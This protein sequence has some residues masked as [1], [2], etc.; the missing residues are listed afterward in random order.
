MPNRFEPKQLREAAE[1][2]TYHDAGTHG[3][4][5]RLVWERRNES[6][7]ARL[8][9]GVEFLGKWRALRF[10]GG[11]TAFRRIC[12]T[13]LRKNL[14]DLQH[15]QGRDLYSLAPEDFQ[16]VLKD[17]FELP[18]LRSPSNH[19]WQSTPFLPPRNCHGL[20]PSNSQ[21][22]IQTTLGPRELRVIPA[23]RMETTP[24]YA[25]QKRQSATALGG[26]PQAF[27]ADLS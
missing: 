17:Q 22:H 8:D 12:T 19:I 20:G 23:L 6:P 15:L 9:D 18:R 2:C 24:R 11:G 21:E 27:S 7:V 5:P 25:Q 10:K 14:T 3:V 16:T 26:T 1:K 13:W 4:W